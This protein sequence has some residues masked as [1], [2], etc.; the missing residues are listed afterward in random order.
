MVVEYTSPTHADL[1]LKESFINLINRR[2]SGSRFFQALKGVSFEINKGDCVGF[3]GPN[4]CGK[5]TLLK[6]IAGII[7]PR[8]G[9]LVSS[10][11]IAPLIEL[12][13][14]FDGELSGED[15]IWMSCSLMGV[16]EEVIKNKLDDI[17]EFAELGDFIHAPVKTYSSGMYM[18]LG[19]A[20]STVIEPDILV[21]DEILA[22]GDARFQ[23]KCLNR[24]REIQAADKTI[25]LVSHDIHTVKSICNRVI[26]LWRGE[27][28]FD[29]D[30]DMAFEIYNQ[31][32]YEKHISDPHAVAR[33]VLRRAELMKN[34]NQVLRD[35]V[36]GVE[37]VAAYLTEEKGSSRRVLHIESIFYSH[38]DHTE[39]LAIGF[40]LKNRHNQRVYGNNTSFQRN[41]ATPD[42]E[43]LKRRGRKLIRWSYDCTDLASGTY[44]IDICI[45]NNEI[46]EIYQ[47]IEKS[48]S[49]T[50]NHPSDVYNH[51]GN[52]IELMPVA[53]QIGEKA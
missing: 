29:G 43:Q 47:F 4:G 31:L 41:I 32:L 42:R 38:Q 53:C 23:T 6:V 46:T 40:Q 16:P 51:D 30:G 24:I 44:S 49:F 19:F 52:A 28:I 5:S 1:S 50:I 36:I 17:I 3:I 12:G 35:Q 21:V 11:V 15:N 48:T 10:G 14:G 33:E 39:P 9:S 2:S 34:N 37:R 7:D 8:S 18:R 25:L 13:A 20:C 26:L 45:S 22:V 27:I